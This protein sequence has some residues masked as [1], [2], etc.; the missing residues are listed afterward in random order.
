MAS[1]ARNG[2]LLF[3]LGVLLFVIDAAGLT[4][5]GE[6]LTALGSVVSFWWL[7][8]FAGAAL[9]LLPRLT[10]GG[11]VPFLD[12]DN[13]ISQERQDIVAETD[14]SRLGRYT[15]RNSYGLALTV[16]AVILFIV[17]LGLQEFGLVALWVAAMI[18]GAI[19][20]A[21]TW[22]SS[23]GI[24][25][26][27]TETIAVRAPDNFAAHSFHIALRQ[28]AEDLGY[29][30]ATSTSPTAAGR[31]SAVADDVF[32]ASGG[33]EATT[34]PIEHS[35]SLAPEV[36]DEY[37]EQILT[38]ATLGVFISLLGITLVGIDAGGAAVSAFGGV[39]FLVG[40]T[41]VAYD[42]ATRTR[43]WAKLYCVEEGTIYSTTVN[44]YDDGVQEAFESPRIDPSSSTTETAAIL[45]VT[46]SAT[47]TPMYGEEN[48]E[49]D[50]EELVAAVED[51]ADEY[52]FSVVD[53]DTALEYDESTADTTAETAATDA[54]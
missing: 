49:E 32:H 46:V 13:G 26:D 23:Y 5:P 45:S 38:V 41:I 54:A 28:Q 42:Y 2:K 24:I 39:F 3:G 35:R 16:S 33:F 6:P 21:I 22:R 14:W 17:A 37:L 8:V 1:T 30:I 11:S 9:V 29:R 19:I 50:F 48:V 40:T 47:C 25:A 31:A 34:R 10:S 15:L 12:I 27:H 53:S 36:D 52:Q 18:I 44:T 51:A 20:V 7:L 4:G 43:E